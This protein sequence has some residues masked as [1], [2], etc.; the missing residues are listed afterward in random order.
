QNVLRSQLSHER[1]VDFLVAKEE[2]VPL[3]AT[4]VKKITSQGAVEVGENNKYLHAH[5][6]VEVSHYTKVHLNYK[7]MANEIREKMNLAHQ[8]YVYC[9]LYRSVGKILE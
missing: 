2:G 6:L 4:T 8:P 5:I 9:K 3:N 1:I 7:E